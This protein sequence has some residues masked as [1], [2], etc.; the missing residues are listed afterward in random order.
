MFNGSF[1]MYQLQASCFIKR[2]SKR[3]TSVVFA[4]VILGMSVLPVFAAT[5]S[6]TVNA[7]ATLA[8]NIKGLNHNLAIQKFYIASTYLYVTQ[9][10]GGTVYL[11]RCL[12]NGNEATYVDEMTLTNCGH[13]QTLDMYTYNDINYLYVSSKADPTT[14]YYWSLQVARVQYSAGV[15]YDYTDLHRFT[16]MNY[17]NKTGSR[18]GTTYRVDGGGN[19]TYTVFRVQTT[20]GTVTYSIYDTVALNQLLDSNEQV[21]MDSSAAKSACVAS[22]T[23]SGDSI[24]RPNGSFQGIDMLDKTS[25]YV[26]GGAEGDTP[27]IALM[28]NTGAY[29]TLV[30]ITNV[31][32]HEIEG[33]QTK[34]DNVYFTIVVDP[35]NKKDTQKIYYVPDSIF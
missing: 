16:Y 12:M 19:S 25:I 32:T 31:G 9:R 27:Q 10:S 20:E 18:L 34:N 30:K 1:S 5:P 35:T 8:Y 2:R 14:S 33:V 7:S 17:A 4:I 26:T 15:T 22:F 13:G 28:S 23:Q 6:K 3:F 11:S 29:Q 21:Q 24:V